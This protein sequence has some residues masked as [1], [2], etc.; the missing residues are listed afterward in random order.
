MGY[1][2]QIESC[3]FS[4]PETKEVLAAIHEMDTKYDHVKRGGSYLEGS[5][6][7][8]WFSWM[9]EDLST[10][11]SVEEVLKTLGFDC[12]TRIMLDGTKAV[13]IF[14]YN[15]K[16]GQEDLF[17][18]VIAPFVSDESY[19]EW[20][21]E[22]GECWRYLVHEGRLTVQHATLSWQEPVRYVHSYFDF[23]HLGEGGTKI[24]LVDPYET[25]SEQISGD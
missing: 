2:V 25:A 12:E 17:L 22:E 9:P 20:R 19:I 3:D 24:R 15:D 7:K 6:D 1:Y 18:A 4:V 14:G 16:T 10:L 11:Q 5:F 13:D 23:Q 21:G 8:K